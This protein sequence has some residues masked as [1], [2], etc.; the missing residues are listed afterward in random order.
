M[1][2]ANTDTTYCTNEK[3]N[4]CWRHISKYKFDDNENYWFMECCEEMEKKS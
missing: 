4:K 3:C 2:K 1:E